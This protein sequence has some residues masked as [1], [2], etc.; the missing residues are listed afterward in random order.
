MGLSLVDGA[1]KNRNAK[2]KKEA[3][4]RGQLLFAF[5]YPASSQQAGSH[6]A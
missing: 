6:Q 4:A 1:K 5:P 3:N 2:W